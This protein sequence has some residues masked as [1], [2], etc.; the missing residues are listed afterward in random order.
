[1]FI[2]WNSP[3]VRLTGRWS[4][5]ES[6]VTDYHIFNKPTAAYTA[7]TAPGSYFEAAF[8][9][10]R[11]LLKFDMRFMTGPVPHLW[12]SVDG[13]A[14]AEVPLDRYLAVEADGEGV[15]V[16]KVFYKGA[17]E[18]LSRWHSPLTAAVCFLGYDAEG[19]GELPP[20][21]RPLM[22]ALGDSITEG[23]LL[24]MDYDTV[25]PY[26]IDQFNR[27]YQ[28]DNLATYPQVAAGILDFRCMSQAYGATGLT[29]EGCGAV[30]RA[31]LTYPYVFEHVEYTG[32]APDYVIVNHGTKDFA[33]PKDEFLMRYKEYVELI[34][35]RAPGAQIVILT[36]FNGAHWDDLHEFYTDCGLSC[37]HFISTKGW[38]P[39]EPLHPVR[40]SHRLAGELLAEAMKKEFGL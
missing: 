38:L 16:V 11:A 19:A 35:S 36:P 7:A 6:D 13:G 26:K 27:P 2:P 17:M 4:R 37:V 1:M 33:A 31:G 9:G 20:D 24:D 29:R 34:H 28:D 23:V 25:P 14:R 3:S 10:E 18:M 30:P 40:Q 32:E 21:T 5:L 12:V 22:E 15:H 8:T 39:K